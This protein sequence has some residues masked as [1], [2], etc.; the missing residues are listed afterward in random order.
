TR[1]SP[2]SPPAVIKNSQTITLG[3]LPSFGVLPGS[4]QVSATAKSNGTPNGQ[5]VSFSTTGPC[6]V[7]APSITNN[8]ST[9]SVTLNN[10]GTCTVIAAQSGGTGYN[11]ATSVSGS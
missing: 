8:V 11:A 10:T 3:A 2:P 5:L 1:Q 9:A 6:S 7:S 4:V